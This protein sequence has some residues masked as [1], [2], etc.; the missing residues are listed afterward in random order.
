MAEG[1]SALAGFSVL[2]E[3]V[4][5]AVRGGASAELREVALAE[6]L[7]THQTRRPQLRQKGGGG[8]NS[9]IQT[10]HQHRVRQSDLAVMAADAVRRALGARNQLTGGGVAAGVLTL[11]TNQNTAAPVS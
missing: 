4:G 7:A 1:G 3:D 10:D 6:R 8:L 9:V 5:G 11:L 2:Q